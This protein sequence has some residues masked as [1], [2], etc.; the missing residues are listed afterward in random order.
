MGNHRWLLPVALVLAVLA[1]V[2]AAAQDTATQAGPGSFAWKGEGT[3]LAGG[4][5][6]LKA[7]LREVVEGRLAALGCTPAAGGAADLLVTGHLARRD[8]EAPVAGLATLVVDLIDT[9]KGTLVWRS[10]DSDMSAASLA[11]AAFA[12]GKSYAWNVMSPRAGV[13]EAFTRAD[14][15]VRNAIEA[16]ML[17]RDW[18]VGPDPAAADVLIAYRV[19]A[20]G[21]TGKEP[22]TATLTVELSRR[23]SDETVWRG[24]R[25]MN[26][27]GPAKLEDAVID[28]VVEIARDYRQGNPSATK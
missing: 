23:G 2:R 14:R 25:T 8:L 15:Y 10:F 6:A 7:R 27:P 16:V 17:F 18:K 12:R 19:A 3:P 13:E 28:A 1:P 11:Q 20:R 4:G 21:T 5:D 26:V 24:G 9:R 22:M